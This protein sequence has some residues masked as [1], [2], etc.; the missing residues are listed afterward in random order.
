MS[1]GGTA[2]VRATARLLWRRGAARLLA[3]RKRHGSA[4]TL[5][6][7]GIWLATRLVFVLITYFAVTF[8]ATNHSASVYP[9]AMLAAWSRKDVGWYLAIAQQG[10]WHPT[11][12]SRGESPTAF[13]PL[14][15]M[16]IAALT[17]MLGASH[18]LLAAMLVSNLGVLAAF[19]GLGLLAAHDAQTSPPATPLRG[20]GSQTP[21]SDAAAM[22]QG[23]PLP[24]KG[25]AEGWEMSPAPP[26]PLGEGA[27][28]RG[29]SRT[30]LIAAAA[31]LA[32]FLAAAYS[33]S[34]FFALA[35]FAL[36]AARRGAWRWAIL[37]G[38]LAGL[39]RFTAVILILPL[40]WE[41]ATQHGWRPHRPRLPWRARTPAPAPPLRGEDRPAPPLPVGEGA[42]GWG[43]PGARTLALG[44][45]VAAA[46]PVGIGL[47]AAYLWARF[48]DPLSFLRAEQQGWGHT[49]TA[50]WL[51]IPH[52][53]YNFFTLPPWSF[54]QARSLVDYGVVL[55]CA[56]VTAIA[57]RRLPGSYRLYM[58][59]LLYLSIASPVTWSSDIFL[60]SGRY[61]LPAIPVY[62]VL[63][64]WV[65]RSATLDALLVGGGFALQ[66]LLTGLW[67][68][69]NIGFI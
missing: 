49:L 32:F 68:A 6:A 15:P 65:G 35:V 12:V 42:G 48:G 47:Y 67:I 39:D 50:P 41:F 61:L 51:S 38:M 26:P 11:A 18:R 10:Y 3:L 56:A 8:A 22:S 14:Y 54:N 52:A 19:I 45:A 69:T 53:I 36:L 43:W 21:P 46:A 64:R 17:F 1:A 29:L 30:V 31:P 2:Q 66:G 24:D 40:A 59:G 63:G 37:C 34:L 4:I 58:L 5:Q 7:A 25:G 57:W 44:A 23:S 27:G 62:L 60:S 28:G 13:F 33:D 16:L 20:E 55:V 9:S